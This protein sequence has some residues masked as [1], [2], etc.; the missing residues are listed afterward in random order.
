MNV[1]SE[2]EVAQSCP[3][4]VLISVEALAKGFDVKDVECVCD[5]RPLRKSLSTAIQ[6]WGRGLGSSPETG[7]TDCYLLAF[8]GNIIRFAADYSEIFCEGLD[9]LDAVEKLD[10]AIRRDDEDKPE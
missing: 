7:Q 10:K 6:M 2:S 5:C 1:K 3:T 4:L 8:S 9:A